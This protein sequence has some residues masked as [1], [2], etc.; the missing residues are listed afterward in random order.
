MAV[1][2]LNDNDETTAT[3]RAI[4][5]TLGC[6][7]GLVEQGLVKGD[8][9][10]SLTSEGLAEFG[11]LVAGGYKPV[12]EEQQGILLYLLTNTDEGTADDG[13]PDA[14]TADEQ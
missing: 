12:A 8:D 10:I 5:F 3:K 7:F 9:A 4:L 2:I 14:G 6:L 11:R 1:D 13:G